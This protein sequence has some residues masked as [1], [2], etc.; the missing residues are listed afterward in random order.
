MRSDW[1]PLSASALV[2]GAMALVLAFA[3]QPA[4]VGGDAS[5]ALKVVADNTGRWLAI[6]VL[7]F[8]A[9][10]AMTLGLPTILS[11]FVR[12]G[13][14][15]AIAGVAVLSVGVLGTSGYAMLMVFFRAL[16]ID[17]AVRGAPLDSVVH[18]G[19]LQIFLYGWVVGFY[20]G[21][22]MLA[23]A[24]LRARR[25]RTWVPVLMIVFVALMPFSSTLGGL[26]Q[27]VQLFLLAV[28][29]T[30]IAIAATSPQALPG[31]ASLVRGPAF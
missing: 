4:G 5:D 17:N 21:V 22:L 6:S 13:R 28:A 14:K 29:F 15:L 8:F 20:G 12:R 24:L 23:V 30:G 11:L 27:V 2:T 16:A 18:D 25:T 3:L 9:S 1:V 10:V 19:G 7:L 31:G 26:T